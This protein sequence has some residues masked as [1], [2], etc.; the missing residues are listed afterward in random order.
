MPRASCLTFMCGIAGFVQFGGGNAD[1]MRD[2]ARTAK[3]LVFASELKAVC[4]HPEFDTTIDP[5]AVNSY[6]RCGY[7]VGSRSIYSM[8]KKVE[9]GTIVRGDS[10]DTYWDPAAIAQRVQHTF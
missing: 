3:T 4:A 2:I 5:E 9:P 6:E 10:V 1:V 8:A 7:V